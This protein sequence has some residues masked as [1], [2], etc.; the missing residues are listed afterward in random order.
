[1]RTEIRRLMVLAAVVAA[2]L[3]VVATPGVPWDFAYDWLAAKAVL[4]GYDPYQPISGLAAAQGLTSSLD[5]LHPRTPGAL[6]L[7]APIGLVPWPAVVTVGQMLV[8]VAAVVLAWVAGQMCGRP[9]LV[10]A[11]PVALLVPPVSGALFTGNTGVLVAALIG[12]S[13]WRG[14]GWGLGAAITMKLWPWLLVPALFVAGRRRMAV[15]AAVVVGALNVAGL[16]MP[17]V[18]LAGAVASVVDAQ[19]HAERSLSVMSMPLGVS[20]AVGLAF[21]GVLW[22]RRWRPVWA[23]PVALAITPLLWGSYLAAL[24]VP[25]VTRRSPPIP[26]DRGA[27]ERLPVT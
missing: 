5:S 25:V 27:V 21:V 6:I 1:M 3:V 18:T 12:W 15:E 4:G 7:Q 17:H 20:V 19:R 16:V 11:G 24:A 9:W 13:W 22:W 2:A 14:T 8:A 23:I 26:K 10:L